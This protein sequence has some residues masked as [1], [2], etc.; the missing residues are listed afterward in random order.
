MMNNRN[1][2][3]GACNAGVRFSLFHSSP[4]FPW[5]AACSS[6]EKGAKDIDL[7]LQDLSNADWTVRSQAVSALGKMKDPQAV[8]PLIKALQD[9][10]G[11]VRRRAASALGEIKDPRAIEPLIV[12][13]EDPES[14]VRR[15]SGRRLG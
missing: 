12:T 10:K 11:Y 8:P 1:S 9:P 4:L 3:S 13:L 15:K 5:M 14:Y 7:L 6:S 2:S